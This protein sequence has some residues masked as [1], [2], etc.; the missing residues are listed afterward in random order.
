MVL[1]L[2]LPDFSLAYYGFAI[3]GMLV[4][5]LSFTAR[6]PVSLD[7]GNGSPSIA[8]IAHQLRMNGLIVEEKPRSV[9]VQ[10]DRWTAVCM[11]Y[12]K[13]NDDFRLVYRLDATNS[14]MAVLI[15]LFLA[16][17]FGILAIPLCIYLLVEAHRY[18]TRFVIPILSGVP[19]P[20]HSP[21]DEIK[22]L[23][24]DSLSECQRLAEDAHRAENSAYED[25]IL[26][27]TVVIG[28][29]G[30]L[31]LLVI[32]SQLAFFDSSYRLA[33]S[34]L[35]AFTISIAA[36]VITVILIRRHTKPKIDALVH[37][38][39]RLNQAATFELTDQM[40]EGNESSIELL[41]SAYDEIP[42]WLNSRRKSLIN[43]YPTMNILMILMSLWGASLAFS[44]A[45][46]LAMGN[47]T[48]GLLSLS[49]GVML[50]ALAFS[51]QRKIMAMESA[52]ETRLAQEWGRR[53]ER[54]QRMI[55]LHLEENGN[56]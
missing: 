21:R 6:F 19:G 24:V 53:R 1:L 23:L 34:M 12:R 43:R 26:I 18:A 38:V 2:F 3:G 5:V 32:L 25:S 48:I 31:A 28:L 49:I 17:I 55:G 35:L 4:V 9:N 36:A 52:E 16:Q 11:E 13:R 46:G 54:L 42:Q 44:G 56:A 27:A 50:V 29:F 15:F 30:G 47:A 8:D 51:L 7:Q 40:Q 10:I 41:F 22:G 33:A 45:F 20:S 39:V 14:T 37:W